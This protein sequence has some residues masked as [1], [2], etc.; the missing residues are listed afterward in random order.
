M[1]HVLVLR[2]PLLLAW[3]LLLL[4]NACVLVRTDKVE[5]GDGDETAAASAV[6]DPG[7][8]S[9][10]DAD[11]QRLEWARTDLRLA[12]LAAKLDQLR[13]QR[14]IGEAQRALTEARQDLETFETAERPAR[15][16]DAQLDLDRT[17]QSRDESRAE[18]AEL[19]AMYAAEEFAAATKELVLQRGRKQL[20]FAER[21]LALEHQQ[22]EKLER[23]DLPRQQEKL[24]FALKKAEH[25]LHIAE[26]E[27]ER[28]KL[29][30]GL[31]IDKARKEV[32]DLERKHDAATP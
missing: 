15:L 11:A 22:R 7:S 25:E 3:F 32:H 23:H 1:F 8:P 13:A 21:R 4:A 12:E 19:E 28:D 14:S 17:I 16:A 29:A 27:A 9:K 24:Q 2:L 5:M 30:A 6:A 31:S 18:L 10:G 20:E 26:V